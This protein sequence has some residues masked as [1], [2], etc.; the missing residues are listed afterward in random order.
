MATTLGS[1]GI[2]YNDGTSQQTAWTGFRSQVFTSS[3]TFTIPTGITSLRI[4]VQGGGGS[5]G[6]GSGGCAIS[7]LT[8]LTPGATLA[9]SIGGVSATS[10]V[11]S[12]TQ[13]ITTISGTGTSGTGPGSASGGTLNI[14]GGYGDGTNGAD[15]VWGRGGSSG[16]PGR[17]YG[18]GGGSG[19]GGT[20]GIVVFD[21]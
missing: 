6:G 19:Q 17:G 5:G 20:P 14:N 15:S 1:T 7:Y 8:G 11:S 2:T 13:A 16:Q 10:S 12:G 18:C 4:T 21:W 3:G 9:V